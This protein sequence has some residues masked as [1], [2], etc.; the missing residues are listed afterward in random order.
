M[1]FGAASSCGSEAPGEAGVGQDAGDGFG[2]RAF[3]AGRN[4][5]GG[6]VFDHGF[7]DAGAPEADDGQADGLGFAERDGEAFG[8]AAGGNDAGRD[9]EAGAIHEFSDYA[10]GLGS[11]EGAVA[12]GVTRQSAQR[13][14]ERTVTD[15]EKPGGGVTFFDFDHGANEVSAPFLFDKAADEQDDGVEIVGAEGV[16]RKEVEVDSDGKGAEFCFRHTALE[17]LAADVVGDAN[18]EAGAVAELGL[19]AEV[20]ATGGV[21]VENLVGQPVASNEDWV[22]DPR[23]RGRRHG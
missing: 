2:E 5:Q 23:N 4:E 19:T 11:E 10:G 21:A 8:V 16:R 13:I 17:C 20:G 12:K 6:F 3:I 9:D 18:E 15:D 22:S 7:G 1:L 14:E